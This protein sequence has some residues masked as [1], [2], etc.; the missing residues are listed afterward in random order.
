MILSDKCPKNLKKIDV[1]SLKRDIPKFF[2]S[3]SEEEVANWKKLLLQFEDG[4]FLK[5]SETTVWPLE[6]LLA[7]ERSAVSRSNQADAIPEALNELRRKETAPLEPVSF[8]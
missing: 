2:C 7:S 4:S 6:S 5:T 8:F 1:T 3:M